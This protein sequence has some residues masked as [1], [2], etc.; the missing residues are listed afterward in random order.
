MLLL[1]ELHC[2]VVVEDNGV[3]WGDFPLWGALQNEPCS[4]EWKLAIRT[5]F[6]IRRQGCHSQGKIS[7]K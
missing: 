4:V 6:I 3:L 7:G 2:K 1:P 5:Y